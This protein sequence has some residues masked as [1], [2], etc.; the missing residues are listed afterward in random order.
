M[1]FKRIFSIFISMILF[2]SMVY[3]TEITTYAK[4][5]LK[6]QIIERC[7]ADPAYRFIITNHLPEIATNM[8]IGLE[9]GRID[10]LF[11]KNHI[12]HLLDID[13]AAFDSYFHSTDSEEIIHDFFYL[14]DDIQSSFI[15]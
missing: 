14:I 7:I 9:Q 15:W 11:P 10:L 2:I 12:M 5:N 13:E 8:V 3:I 1:N 4:L 6:G